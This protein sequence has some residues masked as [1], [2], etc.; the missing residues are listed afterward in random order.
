M[1]DLFLVESEGEDRLQ[2]AEPTT[3]HGWFRGKFGIQSQR[4][5]PPKTMMAIPATLT[6]APITSQAVTATRSTL[7]SQSMAT[8]TYT[9]PYAA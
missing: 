2:S 4:F 3:P 8:A 1:S 7:H 5:Q 9:P 6:V